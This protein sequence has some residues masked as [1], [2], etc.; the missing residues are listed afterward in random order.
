MQTVIFELCLFPYDA[1]CDLLACSTFLFDLCKKVIIVILITRHYESLI[2][3]LS[4]VA[5][6]NRLN[7]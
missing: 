4:N 5:L 6:N 3:E 1:V 7:A 2:L